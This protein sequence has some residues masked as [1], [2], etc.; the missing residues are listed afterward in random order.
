MDV[1][2]NGFVWL[3]QHKKYL[4]ILYTVVA[5]LSFLGGFFAFQRWEGQ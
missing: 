1:L 4:Y 5:I 3:Y 2:L